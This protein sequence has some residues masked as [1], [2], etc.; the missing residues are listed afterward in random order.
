MKDSEFDQRDLFSYT[1]ARKI[2][3]CKEMDSSTLTSKGQTTIPKSIRTRLGLASGD[4]IE[5]VIEPDGRVVLLP[6]NR[7]IADLA[8]TLKHR[9]RI[10]APTL[11]ELDQ[12]IRKRHHP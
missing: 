7:H 11:E 4:R 6:A 10:P 2:R 5:Y 1:K 8:G 12:T 3:N 9:T